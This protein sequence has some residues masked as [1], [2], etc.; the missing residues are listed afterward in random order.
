MK[1]LYVATVGGFMPFFK[2]LVKELIDKGNTVDFAA[3]QSSS[4]V[5]DYYK[6]WGC[7]VY[8]ISCSR[9]PFSFGNIKA[10]REIKKI[11]KDYDIVHCHTPLAAVATRFACKSLR[12]N[13]LKVIYTAHGFHF[14]KGAPIKNWIIY[15]PIEKL[16]AKWTDVLITINKEDYTFAMKKMKAKQI[17]YVPGVGVDI[18]K[19][20]NVIIDRNAKRKELG[21][22]S[23]AFELVSVGELNNNKNHQIVIKAISKLEQKENIHYVIAGSGENREKLEMLAKKL[24]VNLHLLGYRNDVIDIYKSADICVFPSIREGLGIAAIEGMMCELPLICSINRGTKEF[25][26]EGAIGCQHD[27]D[28]Q[29][30]YAIDQLYKNRFNCIKMGQINKEVAKQFDVEIINKKIIGIYNEK[31]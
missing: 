24:N 27:D 3:N 25:V 5:P 30:S 1:I 21:V 2:N 11:A 10:I 26:S 8:D 19:I 6:E 28:S 23:N 14:Y 20:T 12:K 22:P 13:G 18:N 4:K 17:E 9:S 15:Y 16:C 29:F 31:N 7:K